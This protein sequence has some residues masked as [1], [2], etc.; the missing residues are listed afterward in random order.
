MGTVPAVVSC[1]GAE[2]QR[3]PS[4][5]CRYFSRM[6]TAPEKGHDLVEM[7]LPGDLTPPPCNPAAP[8]NPLSTQKDALGGHV[9]GMPP[10]LAQQDRSRGAAT[11][12][13]PP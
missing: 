9:P 6:S 3:F 12:G 10:S 5:P 11:D 1:S 4:L 8:L 13:E 7:Q 2:L